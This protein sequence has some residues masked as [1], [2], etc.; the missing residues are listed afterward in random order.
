MKWWNFTQLFIA[1]GISFP[2]QSYVGLAT[3]IY[4][5]LEHNPLEHSTISYKRSKSSPWIGTSWSLYKVSSVPN[6]CMLYRGSCSLHSASPKFHLVTFSYKSTY[7]LALELRIRTSSV[8]AFMVLGSAPLSSTGYPDPTHWF[9]GY[10]HST[11]LCIHLTV[12]F[13][14]ALLSFIT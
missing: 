10:I 5:V 9:Y 14:L 3:L 1:N 2:F 11:K 6:K 7:G 13:E 8:L 4:R 12:N